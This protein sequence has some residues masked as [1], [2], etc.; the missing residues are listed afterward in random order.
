[1]NIED[2]LR[3]AQAKGLNAPPSWDSRAL[4]RIDTLAARLAEADA[5]RAEAQELLRECLRYPH[6]LTSDHS[7][8]C[9]RAMHNLNRATG[10]ASVGQEQK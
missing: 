8:L 7:T 3:I 5:I 1:M 4:A 10:S 9:A 2:E 6:K